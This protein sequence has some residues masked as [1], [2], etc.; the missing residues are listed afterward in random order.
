MLSSAGGRQTQL[1]DELSLKRLGLTS[2]QEKGCSNNSLM[3]LFSVLPHKSIFPKVLL[4]ECAVYGRWYT[5]MVLIGLNRMVCVCVFACNNNTGVFIGTSCLPLCSPGPCRQRVLPGPGRPGDQ[6]S[7]RQPKT[8]ETL[9]HQAIHGNGRTHVCMRKNMFV[10]CACEDSQ[11]QSHVSSDT[12][13][14]T[15]TLWSFCFLH[16]DNLPFIKRLF[17]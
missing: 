8:M 12:I 3:C 2:R 4:G 13:T 1:W 7:R 16:Y 15:V 5:K 9:R 14:V 10:H 17:L 6:V 11:R